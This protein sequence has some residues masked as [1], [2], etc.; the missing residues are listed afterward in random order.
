MAVRDHVPVLLLI[1]QV[2]ERSEKRRYMASGTAMAQDK[3]RVDTC[4][5]RQKDAHRFGDTSNLLSTAELHRLA[6]LST[7]KG[8]E[9][10]KMYEQ[11]CGAMR[12]NPNHFTISDLAA[13][14][15]RH[16][17]TARDHEG[18]GIVALCLS[19]RWVARTSRCTR[20]AARDGH[21]RSAAGGSTM[22]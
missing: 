6:P 7:T 18:T 20:S 2:S 19:F 13:Q 9:D 5:T 14:Q 15:E 12:R 4:G 1:A 8:S 17:G 10:K 3:A 21:R 16:Q 22:T 11:R